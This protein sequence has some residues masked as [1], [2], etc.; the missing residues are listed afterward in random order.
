M[1]K[2]CNRIL[3]VRQAA[4]YVAHKMRWR[5]SQNIAEKEINVEMMLFTSKLELSRSHRMHIYPMFYKDLYHHCSRV[6]HKRAACL[7]S[8]VKLM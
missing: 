2:R 5:C 6:S 4:F 3:D 1:Q 8:H 7:E